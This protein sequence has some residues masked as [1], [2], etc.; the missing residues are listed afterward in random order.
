MLL[1]SVEFNH[2]IV[3]VEI[4]KKDIYLEL[5]D[6]FL[7]F[8]TLPNSLY[9][10]NSLIISFDKAENENSKL[11][12]IPTEN[13]LLNVN[14]SKTIVNITDKSKEFLVLQTINGANKS[15]YNELFSAITTDEIRKSKLEEDYNAILKK[16]VVLTSSKMLPNDSFDS[17]IVYNTAFLVT[18][19]LQ[20]VGSIKIV[21]IP[22]IEKAY[23]RDIIS[24]ETRNFDINYF[25]KIISV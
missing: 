4:D 11:I 10:A 5:T 16:V 6:K 13:S 3:K 22:F 1:P 19:K 12:S 25:N 20:S 9:Q 8:N 21:E 18:E 23:T 24:T 15:Y 7:P 17:E 14:T 2:C